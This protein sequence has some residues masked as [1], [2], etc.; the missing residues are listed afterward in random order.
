MK[1]LALLILNQI[2][3]YFS[4]FISLLVG[5]KSFV[6]QYNDDKQQTIAEA[7]VFFGISFVILMILTW[8]LIPTKVESAQYLATQALLYLILVAVA[9]GITLASWRLVGGKAP[10]ARFFVI[11]CYYGGMFIVCNMII[12]FCAF[13]LLKLLDPEAYPIMVDSLT[14]IQVENKKLTALVADPNNT[15]H[16]IPLLAFFLIFFI[17]LV[18]MTFWGIL[19]WGAYREINGLSKMRSFAAGMISL[20][21]TLVVFPITTLFQSGLG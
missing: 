13:G 15:Q 19:G 4:N 1:D 14:H 5:P 17:D 21:L 10:F 18:V 11:T 9:T 16:I 20:L 7:M 8:P 2:P 6:R 3:K 12:L